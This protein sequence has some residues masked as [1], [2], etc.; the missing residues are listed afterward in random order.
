MLIWFSEQC[1]SLSVWHTVHHKHG[2]HGKYFHFNEKAMDY[3][4]GN[5]DWEYK[6][7]N[8][9]Q[10]GSRTWSGSVK[11]WRSTSDTDANG[12]RN[13]HGAENQWS[14]GDTIVMH[15]CRRKKGQHIHFG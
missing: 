2:D 15:N 12:R 13:F 1:P 11:V 4:V 8:I 3:M 10:S 6:V 7:F 14:P 5:T 9:I